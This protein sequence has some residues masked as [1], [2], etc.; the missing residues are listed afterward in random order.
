MIDYY[1]HQIGPI[2]K[3]YTYNRLN[4]ILEMKVI[5]SR[6]YLEK[7]GII[8]DERNQSFRIRDYNEKDNCPNTENKFNKNIYN[9]I[10]IYINADLHKNRVSLSDPHNHFIKKSIRNKSSITC[11][12]FNYHYIGFA[13]SRDIQVIPKE[14]TNG[15]ALGEIQVYDKIDTNY[16]IGL[17]LPF[18]KK[19][20]NNEY[21]GFI[22]KIYSL[23][24]QNEF[25]L[26]I[27]NYE[28]EL[29]KP[30]RNK[31]L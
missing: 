22:D 2:D 11:T 17:I 8:Q 19:Q 7:N 16:I 15:L 20:A 14:D 13:I 27:Y 6:D 21:S 4:S 25:Y 18:S 31:I 30:K 26:D 28:G 3:D 1:I 12:C 10:D 24:E 5:G 9:N 23:C 29:I